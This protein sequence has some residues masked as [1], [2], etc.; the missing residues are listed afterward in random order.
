VV[1]AP[2]GSHPFSS[3]GFYDLDKEHIKE[4]VEA[5]KA[6]VKGN[7][8]PFNQYLKKYVFDPES[9]EDY[10]EIIGVKRLH[11]LYKW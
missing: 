5:A 3:D 7:A 4:Y 8:E 10:L 9:H 6:C 2:Y 11:S 1:S